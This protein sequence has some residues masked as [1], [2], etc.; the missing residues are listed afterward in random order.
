MKLHRPVQASC[1]THLPTSI[2][3]GVTIHS[4]GLKNSETGKTWNRYV[5]SPS[6]GNLE[7]TSDSQR[8]SDAS[9]VHTEHKSHFPVAI[10]FKNQI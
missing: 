3:F 9:K 8:S 2:L 6:C 5:A 1:S 7:S 10:A 4:W